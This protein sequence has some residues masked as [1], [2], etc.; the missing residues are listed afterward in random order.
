MASIG[1]ITVWVESENINYE[2]ESTEHPVEKGIELTDH[3]KVNPISLDISGEIV[4]Q[5]AEELKERINA[6]MKKG[7][8]ITYSGNNTL[9]NVQIK[10]FKATHSNKI[11]GGFTFNMQIKQ[12]RIAKSAY[13]A[14]S[15]TAS[16]KS[17]GTQ[18][19][20][21]NVKKGL[22]IIH[23]VKKGDTCWDIAQKYNTTVKAVN[24][25]NNILNVTTNG[26]WT[27]LK[28]GAHLIVGQR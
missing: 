7:A 25:L 8:L 1:G 13:Q 16:R 6:L 15:F 3:V 24:K 10:S 17:T 4:G 12:V 11:W 20:Q 14:N 23:T 19:I 21:K 26:A 5:N 27:T 28:I 2:V 22:P 9:S 18:Q